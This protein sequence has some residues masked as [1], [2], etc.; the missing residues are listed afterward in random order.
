[1]FTRWF[2][3]PFQTLVDVWRFEE[4]TLALI[5]DF[6]KLE[7]EVYAQG[8]RERE[9]TNLHHNC[10]PRFLEYN[11]IYNFRKDFH[12]F[13]HFYKYQVVRH[14]HWY[15]RKKKFAYLSTPQMHLINHITLAIFL[16]IYLYLPRNMLPYN[17]RHIDI[18]KSHLYLCTC[19]CFYSQPT[20]TRRHLDK[21][22]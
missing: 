4:A 15:L 18:D 17:K 13:L 1:M 5:N 7:K 22:I 8:E 16:N 21:N 2:Y 3:G 19:R 20:C 10:I 12:K 11:G 6:Q 9:R 14:T